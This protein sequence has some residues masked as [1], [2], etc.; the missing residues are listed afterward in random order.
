MNA[1]TYIQFENLMSQ[2]NLKY[3]VEHTHVQI[4]DFITTQNINNQ[5]VSVSDVLAQR[6]ISS[7]AT[8]HLRLQQLIKLGLL[9][10]SHPS[11][12]RKKLLTITE[13]TK[14]RMQEVCNLLKE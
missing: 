1:Q 8:I 10:I 2:I 5:E 13:K 3:G 9:N 11:D 4:L 12:Q 7:P 6:N 14:S